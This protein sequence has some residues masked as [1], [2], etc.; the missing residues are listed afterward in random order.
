MPDDDQP[1]LFPPSSEPTTSF[2]AAESVAELTGR[3]RR[4]VFDFIA[5]R[6]SYGATSDEVEAAFAMRHQNIS[7]RIWELKNMGRIYASETR[8]LTRSGRQARVNKVT[9]IV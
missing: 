4:A 8:R 1:D 5:D 9:G 7:A 6:G 2:E 3:W